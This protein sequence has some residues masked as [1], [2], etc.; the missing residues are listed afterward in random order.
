[1]GS[2]LTITDFRWQ[3]V[4][5]PADQQRWT[6]HFI[7]VADN[8]RKFWKREGF[9]D[10][11]LSSGAP[12]LEITAIWST[13]ETL[14]STWKYIMPSVK[15][16]LANWGLL[17]CE[18]WIIFQFWA[19]VSLERHDRL[20]WLDLWV[21]WS[22]SVP[23]LSRQMLVCLCPCC[24]CRACRRGSAGCT[25]WCVVLQSSWCQQ[26]WSGLQ[27]GDQDQENGSHKIVLNF[28]WS[29]EPT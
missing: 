7:D 22:V 24:W 13:T 18:S 4:A 25:I 19:V 15:W 14:S 20:A 21:S 28:N 2:F 11:S 29:V 10:H 5:V 3:W 26:G 23:R 16:L 6:Q 27:S 9:T 8:G 17:F 1:M 12:P